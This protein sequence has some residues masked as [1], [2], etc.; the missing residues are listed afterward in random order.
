[1]NKISAKIKSKQLAKKQVTQETLEDHREA[2]LSKGRKLKAQM[3]QL[4]K[5]IVMVAAGIAA[6]I[7]VVAGAVGYLGLYVFQSTDDITFRFTEVLPLP[8]AKV[9]GEWVRYGDYLLVYRSS[10]RPVEKQGGGRLEDN[11]ENHALIMHYKNEA[12]D[13]AVRFTYARKLASELGVEVDQSEID[14]AIRA[15]RTVDGQEWSED[16]FTQAI[17]DNFGLSRREYERLVSRTL[18][19]QEVMEA[20]DTEAQELSTKVGKA[21]SDGVSFDDLID[22]F[23]GITVETSDGLVGEM[24]IDGGRA[25]MALQQETGKISERFVSKS[26]DG[27]YFVK[28][29]EK[30]GDQVKY[31]SVFIPFTEFTKRIEQVHA[32]GGIQKFIS[33]ETE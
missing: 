29:V 33:L 26:G 7:L 21:L 18:L 31:V 25:K 8:V 2:V 20:V 1:M 9:D 17:F 28:T 11:E 19:L 22:K 23:A 4:Q 14:E 15:Y 3:T 12:M 24:D 5:R 6:L 16:R 27:Y 30:S 13:L 32:D 10:I